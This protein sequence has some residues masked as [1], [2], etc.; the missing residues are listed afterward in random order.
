MMFNVTD[1]LKYALPV[2]QTISTIISNT[3]TRA[4]TKNTQP[5]QLPDT[6][7]KCVVPV[8][9]EKSPSKVIVNMDINFHVYGNDNANKET[10]EGLNF[11]KTFII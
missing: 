5:A 6:T 2:A 4:E 7:Q 11:Q 3:N 9:V 8:E 10:L 1:V